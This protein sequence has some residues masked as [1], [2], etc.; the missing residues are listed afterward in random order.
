MNAVVRDIAGRLGEK[1]MFIDDVA[2]ECY[3]PYRSTH[4]IDLAVRERDFPE[5]RSCLLGMGF[6]HSRSPHL[7]KHAFKGR[8]VGEVD[9]YT[10]TVGEVQ[11]D[12]EMFRRGR[13]LSYGGTRVFAASL[14][15][16]L[17]LKLAAGREMD[18][19]DVA[20][21]LHERG[22]ELDLNR[23]RELAGIETLRRAAPAIPDLLPEEYGWQARQRL[24]AWLRDRDLIVPA[25]SRRQVADK[26]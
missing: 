23:L 22:S 14:E 17:R 1:V 12:E 25:R 8:D 16:L 10:R 24:K 13:E 7:V 20:V 6:S 19:S 11:I 5:L 3:A 2:V 18:L 4:D 9:V 26:R 21:L 15:D